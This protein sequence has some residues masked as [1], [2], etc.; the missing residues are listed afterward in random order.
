MSARAGRG[1]WGLERTEGTEGAEGGREAF[2]L[3]PRRLRSRRGL[4]ELPAGRQRR[5]A[6]AGAEPRRL[7][8][9]GAGPPS[10]AREPGEP[11]RPARGPADPDPSAGAAVE[12]ARWLRAPRTRPPRAGPGRLPRGRERG[13][14]GGCCREGLPGGAAVRPPRPRGWVRPGATGRRVA[15]ARRLR[16]PPP[17][18]PKW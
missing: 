16:P 18:A 1:R 6:E 10:A 7:R 17:R 13:G 8:V 12:P 14:P 15:G 2:L 3:L 11:P 9:A 4:A 5:A